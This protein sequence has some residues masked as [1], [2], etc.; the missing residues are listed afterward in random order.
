MIGSF[1][2]ATAG[3]IIFGPGRVKELPK[4]AREFGTRVF[5]VTGGDQGR[6]RNV[7]QALET[8]GLELGHCAITGEPSVADVESGAGSA[9][10][11]R[12]TVV[13]GIGGGSVIDAAKANALI[14]KYGG[15]YGQRCAPCRTRM[16]STMFCLTR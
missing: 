1:D 15:R 8:A 5:L 9:R 14:L 7:I 10:N 4:L 13:I 12:A 3:R 2:F 11:H 16:T 6:H